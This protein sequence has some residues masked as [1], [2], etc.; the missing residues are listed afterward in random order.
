VG[1]NGYHKR[2]KA[3]EI[4]RSQFLATAEF[5]EKNIPPKV[6]KKQNGYPESGMGSGTG[7]GMG[8]GKVDQM[9]IPDFKAQSYKKS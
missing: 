7:S 8:S 4:F 5:F 6:E 2:P 1:I 9:D 3:S